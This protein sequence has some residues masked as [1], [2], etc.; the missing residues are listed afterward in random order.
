MSMKFVANFGEQVTGILGLA[1]VLRIYQVLF[2]E[3]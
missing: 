1:A 2:V 3:T